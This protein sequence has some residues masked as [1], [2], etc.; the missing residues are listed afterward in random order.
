MKGY[1]AGRTLTVQDGCGDERYAVDCDLHHIVACSSKQLYVT[2]YLFLLSAQKCQLVSIFLHNNC[3]P[4]HNV[5]H[6]IDSDCTANHAIFQRVVS[7]KFYFIFI[8]TGYVNHHPYGHIPLLLFCISF[9]TSLLL[10]TNGFIYRY[11]QVCRTHLFNAYM[12]TR[13]RVIATA[14]NLLLLVNYVLLIYIGFWPNEFFTQLVNSTIVIPGFDIT[15]R[16]F[17]GFSMTV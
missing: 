13:S 3:C 16:S 10:V 5:F 6:G 12:T 14:I 15:N 2:R 1:S 9:F 11:L 17:I 4:R 7:Q 8:S